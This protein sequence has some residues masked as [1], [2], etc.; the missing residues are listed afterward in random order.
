VWPWLFIAYLAWAAG[1]W[2]VAAISNTA[3]QP[4]SPPP[5]ARDAGHRA[6]VRHGE[7]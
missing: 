5:N 6:E 2:I 3:Q 4:G 7:D 1:S